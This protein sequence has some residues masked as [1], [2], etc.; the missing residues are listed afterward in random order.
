MSSC[1]TPKIVHIFLKRACALHW[2]KSKDIEI[3]ASSVGLD[4]D[5]HSDCETIGLIINQEYSI[6]I[7]TTF[8]GLE[9]NW[10]FVPSSGASFTH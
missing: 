3:K 9:G 4:A 2:S 5:K 10:T 7:S 1:V 6:N 8:Q